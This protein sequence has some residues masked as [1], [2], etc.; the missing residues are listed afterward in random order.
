MFET[1]IFAAL[2]ASVWQCFQMSAIKHI[3]FS[4]LKQMFETHTFAA[5]FGINITMYSNEFNQVYHYF[6][7]KTNARNSYFRCHIWNQHNNVFK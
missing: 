2:L 7:L 4:N 3:I 6:K 5:I 1:Y